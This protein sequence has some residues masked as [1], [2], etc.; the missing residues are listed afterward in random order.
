[1][2]VIG[3]RELVVL[4]FNRQHSLRIPLNFY[5]SN[6]HILYYFEDVARY[7]SKI[8]DF[9]AP[10]VSGAQLGVTAKILG[11]NKLQSLLSR[12]YHAPYARLTSFNTIPAR[13]G[14]TDGQTEFLCQH[15]ALMLT[16]DKMHRVDQ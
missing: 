6:V 10:S 3:L 12:L 11:V 1:M 7:L 8:P 16:G 5:S 14:R 9:Y 15:R 2:A 4:P 13:D